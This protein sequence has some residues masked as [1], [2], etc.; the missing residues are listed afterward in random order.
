[1]IVS[2]NTMQT[3]VKDLSTKFWGIPANSKYRGC[4]PIYIM[5]ER[6]PGL[7]GFT[8]ADYDRSGQI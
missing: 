4:I 6:F 7:A 3:M 2:G 1:M 8:D 5:E